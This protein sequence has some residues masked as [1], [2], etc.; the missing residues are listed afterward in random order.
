M[1]LAGCTARPKSK[2]NAAPKLRRGAAQE[3]PGDVG[4]LW[5]MDWDMMLVDDSYLKTLQQN[6]HPQIFCQSQPPSACWLSISGATFSTRLGTSTPRGGCTGT[7]LRKQL[8]AAAAAKRPSSKERAIVKN[9][10]PRF[11]GKNRRPLSPGMVENMYEK[12]HGKVRWSHI[13]EDEGWLQGELHGMRKCKGSWSTRNGI[14]IIYIYIYI[15]I[16][17]S[18]GSTG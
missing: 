1:A 9:K 13:G 17:T 10:T 14:Y 2:P 15:C 8:P 7:P 5:P 6:I 4:C 12:R 3:K 18:Q 16:G 11:W